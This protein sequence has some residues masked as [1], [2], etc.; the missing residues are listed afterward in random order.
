METVRHLSCNWKR[1]DDL[2]LIGTVEY[3]PVE[4]M[5]RAD[6]CEEVCLCWLVSRGVASLGNRRGVMMT[7][8]Y[9][10]PSLLSSRLRRRCCLPVFGEEQREREDKDTGERERGEVLTAFVIVVIFDG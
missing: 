1:I 6:C 10:T 8:A 4:P 7:R 5:H 3:A 9:L 2:D